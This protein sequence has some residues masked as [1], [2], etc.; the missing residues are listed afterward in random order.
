[1]CLGQGGT[2]RPRTERAFTLLELIL[3]MALL[4]VVMAMAAPM[5]SRFFRGRTLESEAR[6]FLAMT[7]YGQSRAASEGIPMILWIDP[8]ERMYGVREADG[9]SDVD[10]KALEFELHQDLRFEWMA[11]PG[12]QVG[13]RVRSEWTMRFAP[14]GT[15]PENGLRAVGLARGDDGFLVITQAQNRLSYEIQ[16]ATNRIRTL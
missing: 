10:L 15:L 9:Y 11:Q 14:D 5:L 2:V 7:R 3:V 13:N 1:M 16:Q 8:D 6:R 12:A 4:V